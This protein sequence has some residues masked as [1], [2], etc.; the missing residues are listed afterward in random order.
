[1]VGIGICHFCLNSENNDSRVLSIPKAEFLRVLTGIMN[2]PKGDSEFVG[3]A[4]PNNSTLS[5]DVDVDDNKSRLDAIRSRKGKQL[6]RDSFFY[7]QK[8]MEGRGGQDFTA[9]PP[10]DRPELWYGRP[11]ERVI[12][13]TRNVVR[14]RGDADGTGSP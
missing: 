6:K 3:G 8:T 9:P 14:S 11:M 13:G 10:V 5:A 4:G 1:M 7:L 2:Q 12:I